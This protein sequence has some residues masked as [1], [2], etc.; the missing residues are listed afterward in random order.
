MRLTR[1]CCTLFGNLILLASLK[2]REQPVT[3]RIGGAIRPGGKSKASQKHRRN[4]A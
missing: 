3:A 4:H 1:F 2:K